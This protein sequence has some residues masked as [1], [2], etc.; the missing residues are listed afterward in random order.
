MIDG[1]KMPMDKN[2]TSKPG[3]CGDGINTTKVHSRTTSS[4]SATGALQSATTSTPQYIGANREELSA[5]ECHSGNVINTE[6]TSIHSTP[7]QPNPASRQQC[8]HHHHH[9]HY[10]TQKQQRQNSNKL[11]A[12]PK[13]SFISSN[14]ELENSTTCSSS[15]GENIGLSKKAV[16]H[17]PSNNIMQNPTNTPS[18]LPPALKI[19]LYE[20]FGQIEREF[21]VLYSENLGLQ[22]R[23]DE[24]STSGGHTNMIPGSTSTS[25]ISTLTNNLHMLGDIDVNSQPQIIDYGN[26]LSNNPSYLAMQ[27]SIQKDPSQANRFGNQNIQ[28]PEIQHPS[29]HKFLQQSKHPYQPQQPPTHL[30]NIQQMQQPSHHQKSSRV[31]KLRSH[32]NRL[33]QQTTRIMS[34]FAS[35]G[36]SGS[37]AVN[38]TP[39]RK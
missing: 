37:S 18:S 29:S 1:L 8:H 12:A 2:K 16:Q 17:S 24:L 15:G 27:S 13:S 36:P 6:V 21:E 34:N 5:L 22:E 33:R 11:L 10:N 25:T 38:C 23:L 19:R 31:H 26:K 9:H 4:S 30:E 39:L 32:T 7:C 20:L 35:K 28:H 3:T 14:I